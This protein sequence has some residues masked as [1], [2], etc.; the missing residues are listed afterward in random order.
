MYQ[1]S[2][3]RASPMSCGKGEN[4]KADI[5]TCINREF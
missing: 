3:K 1:T 4:I 5:G 2:E